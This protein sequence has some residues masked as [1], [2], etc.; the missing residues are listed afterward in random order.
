[1]KL[2][3]AELAKSELFQDAPECLLDFVIQQCVPRALERGEIL[4]SP[5][6]ENHY[7][8]VLLSG[9]FSLHFEAPDSPEIRELPAGVSVGELS[10]IDET[11]PSAYVI[12]KESCRVLPIHR[13]LLFSLISDANV[14]SRNLLRL[15]TQ[16]I[17]ANTRHIVQDRRQIAELA[18]CATIDSLTGLHNRRWLDNA[19]PC[20]IGHQLKEQTPL[21]VLLIDV[22]HFKIYNDSQ[23]HRG[24]DLALIALSEVIAATIRPC[25][26]SARYGGDEIVVLLQNTDEN[27]AMTVAERIR[28]TIE[29][30]SIVC[31][32]GTR[33]G[34]IT[35]SIGLACSDA[36]STP[37]SLMMAADRQL[38][39]AKAEGRNRICW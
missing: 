27:E 39:R 3:A 35:V 5:E 28:R 10:L 4:L 32:D 11:P 14:V 1:M 20:L 36:D 2:L 31:S 8:Y 19:L 38:Y 37:E 34:A 33:L 7:V 29:T 30:K 23:G 15:L 22:D 17:K 18:D 9:K 16:W 21:S 13:T 6:R 12:A 25:D 24:G 26:F